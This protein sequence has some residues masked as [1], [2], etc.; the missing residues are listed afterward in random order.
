MR[1]LSY[2]LTPVSGN[3][4][5]GPMAVSTSA[6]DTCPSTCPFKDSGCYAASGPLVLHWRKV[7]SGERG[8]SLADFLAKLAALP[9]GLPFRHN[10]AGDLMHNNG[11]IS[12]T[13]MKRMVAAVRHLR[14]YTY[15]HHALT[16][17]ENLSIL[18]YANRNGFTINA[19]CETEQQADST[20]AAGLPAVLVVPPDEQRASWRTDGGNTVLVCPAQRMD[21]ATC[22]SCM[23]CHKRNSRLI[24]GFLAHGNAKRK[25]GAI[26]EGLK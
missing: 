20:I 5:T 25:V 12:R 2:H 18:R 10:Q 4:K 7:T 23:L 6:A 26:V 17:G 11:N 14:A 8:D 9:A 13:F 3:R 1:N 16:K 15:T 24:I 19:S 21:N 22:A